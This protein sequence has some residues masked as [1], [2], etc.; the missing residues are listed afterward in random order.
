VKGK[1]LKQ[2]GETMRAGFKTSEFWQA[3]AAQALA[4]CAL[5]GIVNSRDTELIQESVSKCITGVFALVANA[6]VVF[7]YIKTRFHLK[8]LA[9]Q[10]DEHD[11]AGALPRINVP[12]WLLACTG[13]LLWGSP[14]E[15]QSIFPWRNSVL[16]Q[17]RDHDQKISQ[18]LAQ[19]NLPHLPAPAP[20]II[21]VPA[22]PP[23]QALPIKSQPE[24]AYPIPGQPQQNFPIPGQP[25][26]ILPVP[27][28]P[29]Q[30]PIPGQPRQDLP[31]PGQPQPLPIMPP[32]TGQRPQVYSI[33]RALHNPID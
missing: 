8:V 2:Q 9:T 14:A 18:L 17:M 15:A 20:Q 27:G 6:F 33:K 26:Q 19:Q 7:T 3:L 23:L 10:D 16:Q 1:N 13:L 21:V 31:I 24:Q 5:I 28:Q 4:L 25:Q 22:P 32:V 11:R 12:L 29:Q 30:M